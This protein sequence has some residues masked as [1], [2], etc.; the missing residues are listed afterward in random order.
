MKVSGTNLESL[1]TE[2]YVVYSMAVA[3]A[4]NFIGKGEEYN[5]IGK[6]GAFVSFTPSMDGSYFIAVAGHYNKKFGAIWLTAS[7]IPKWISADESH[8][9]YKQ[10]K[11]LITTNE[12]LKAV[13][14][15]SKNIEDKSE[16]IIIKEKENEQSA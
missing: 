4:H 5:K 9:Y 7:F 10:M 11:V 12:E 15:V 2:E 8:P 3:N 6:T 1:T 13:G 16:S 14:F